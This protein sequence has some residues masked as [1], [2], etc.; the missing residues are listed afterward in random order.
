MNQLRL[1]VNKLALT[2]LD[3]VKDNLELHKRIVGL[4]MK[5]MKYDNMLELKNK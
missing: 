2:V 4:E 3:L 1:V 5:S